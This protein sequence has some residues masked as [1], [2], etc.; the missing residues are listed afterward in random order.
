MAS[1]RNE[2]HHNRCESC[3]EVVCEYFINEDVYFIF[4][5]LQ[6]FTNKAPVYIDNGLIPGNISLVSR[7]FKSMKI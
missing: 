1:F 4:V 5:C 2:G 3:K 6:I 7:A